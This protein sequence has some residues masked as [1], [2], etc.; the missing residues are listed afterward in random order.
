MSVG[1]NSAQPAYRRE[2]PTRA[3]ARRAVL[4]RS[5]HGFEYLK[6]H[7]THYLTESL[8]FANKPLHFYLFTACSPRRRM[9]LGRAPMSLHRPIHVTIG[10]LLQR[11]PNS[12][13][14]KCFPSTNFTIGARKRSVHGDSGHGGHSNAFLVI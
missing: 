7:P 13:P 10:A 3:R 5:P 9:A 14:N 12:S 2:K 8:T 4:H 1:L 11:R 6:K